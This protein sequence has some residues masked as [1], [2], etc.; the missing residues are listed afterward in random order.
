MNKKIPVSYENHKKQV[1]CNVIE[2]WRIRAQSSG[3]K[4]DMSPAFST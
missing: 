4:F 1:F 3:K 2:C